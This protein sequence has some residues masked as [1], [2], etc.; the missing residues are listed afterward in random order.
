[1]SQQ[2]RVAVIGAG[3]WGTTVASLAAANAPTTLWARRAELAEEIDRLHV[4]ADYLPDL[5]LHPELRAT[6]SLADAVSTAD[7]VVV[8]VPSHGLR[9]V[10]EQAADH[11][12]PWVP[13]VSLVKGLEHGSRLRM[14]QVIEEVLPG[15][16]AG[17]LTG[18]NLAREVM[19]GHAAAA[20]VAMP[21][22]RVAAPLQDIFKAPLFRVYR[23]TD[24]VGAEIAGALKNVFAIAAGM[25]SGLGTGDN[26]RALV[27]CRAIAEMT[28]LGVAMGGDQLTFAGLAGVGDLLATCISPLSRNRMVGEKLAQG[29]SVDEI[30]AE[31][32]MVAEGVKT[33]AVVRELAD[34]HGVEMPIVAEVDA[35]V[36]EGRTPEEAYAGLLRRLPHTEFEGVAKP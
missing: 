26:T 6:C 20:V 30:T 2:A 36:N 12:R 14:T 32:N 29:R 19:S 9:A 25:S 23:S 28:R 4:S 3:S 33:V 18:P 22:Q 34:E 35:V 31:M 7:V 15:H 16:P 24:V 17:V 8:A 21:D 11:I 5:E 13:V 10:L 27:I 1:M